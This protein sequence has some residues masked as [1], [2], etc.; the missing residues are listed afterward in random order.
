ME[1][2]KI[3]QLKQAILDKACVK[4]DVFGITK[5][6]F[7]DLKQ[8]LGE[9][10]NEVRNFVAPKDGRVAVE[11]KTTG[12]YEAQM[13]MAGDTIIFHM[14]TNVFSFPNSHMIYK[15]P[16]VMKDPK[17][18]YCGIINIYNFLTDSYRF[19]RLND[20]GY[21]VGRIFVNHERHFFVE[22]RHQLGFL[23]NDF[24]NAVLDAQSLR[25]VIE[26][27]LL[28]VIDFDLYTPP[29]QAVKEVSLDDMQMLSQDLRLKTGKR[30]GFRFEA[31]DSGAR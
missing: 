27:A 4:Q 1:G 2:S 25:L 8:V 31:N 12:P 7:K 9:V 26:T 29:Y 11:L 3:D 23:F 24:S 19:N 21:L 6:V 5:E 30:L 28:H 10:T 20:S 22:G 17:K 15:S 14:H 16:Y 18:A 13:T